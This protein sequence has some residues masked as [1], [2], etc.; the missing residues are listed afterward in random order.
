MYLMA[1]IKNEAWA[2]KQ[3]ES[4]GISPAGRPVASRHVLPAALRL[5]EV[6]SVYGNSV[7]LLMT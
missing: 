1:Y 4:D 3:V 5:Y 7:P 2:R 6:L